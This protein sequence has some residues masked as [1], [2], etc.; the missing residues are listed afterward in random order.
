MP[1]LARRGLAGRLSCKER[2][3]R[4]WDRFD[5]QGPAAAPNRRQRT[6]PI[7]QERRGRV[8]HT[9][10]PSDAS[11]SAQGPPNA[12]FWQCQKGQMMGLR[13]REVYVW[14]GTQRAFPTSLENRPHHVALAR[15]GGGGSIERK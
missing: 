9:Q 1:R 11:P 3:S 13:W 14:G 12:P 7:P 4:K 10:G 5:P 15:F 2:Y 8:S 6:A